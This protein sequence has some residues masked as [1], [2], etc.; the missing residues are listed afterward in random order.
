[1]KWMKERDLLIA[2]TMA[3]VQSVSGK[4]PEAET[5]A[6]V[7]V[8]GPPPAKFEPVAKLETARPAPADTGPRQA[9]TPPSQHAAPVIAAP[10]VEVAP[11]VSRELPRPV[12]LPRPDWR[13]DF[14]SE[15]KARVANFRAQQERFSR[16]REAY[17]TATMAK[18]H[19]T[20]NE[21]DIPL[22]RIG[23]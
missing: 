1:M 20:L 13:E 17:C 11:V 5:T 14:Q 9:E 10:T 18:V 6:A 8:V 15:I 2:Q 4:M 23:K 12:S 19:A 7:P 22:P 21:S 16:E 3:F